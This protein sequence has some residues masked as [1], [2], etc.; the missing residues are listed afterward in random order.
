MSTSTKAESVLTAEVSPWLKP[1]HFKP[2][3]SGNPGGRR[4][5][6]LTEALENELTPDVCKR[7]AQ[8]MV[9]KAEAASV[10]HFES[11]ADR[12]EGKVGNDDGDSNGNIAITIR[13]D[14][15]RP[16]AVLGPTLPE[17]TEEE[18]AS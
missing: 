13:L 5:K 17:S 14:V 9:A 6:P 12:V 3:E 18:H 15:P 8:K 7:I 1:Y 10:M 4:K 16:I 2:G 11:I